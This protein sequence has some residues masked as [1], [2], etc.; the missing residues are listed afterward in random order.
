MANRIITI[1]REYGSGGRLVGR[2]VAEKLGIPFYDKEL[3]ALIAQKS[4]YDIT[5]I[6]ETGEYSTTSSRLFNMAIPYLAVQS[7][8]TPETMPIADKLHILQSN[9]VSEVARGGPCVIV[10]RSADYILRDRDDVLN[11]FIFS[12]M[13]HKKARAIEYF[14]IAPENVE[15]ALA[16]KDKLRAKHYKH[17]TGRTWGMATNYHVALD[18]GLLGVD[19]CVEVLAGIARRL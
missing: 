8:Y 13:E 19:G 2:L 4:G 7:G 16:H 3:I 10:G 9:V 17:Y 6:E 15:K 12:D 5:F 11:A 14:N 1:S 18:S